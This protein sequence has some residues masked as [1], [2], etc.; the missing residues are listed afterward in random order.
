MDLCINLGVSLPINEE[1][2]Q[3]RLNGS[4]PS[5]GIGVVPVSIYQRKALMRVILDGY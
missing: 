2:S 3:H 5:D 1:L 4:D